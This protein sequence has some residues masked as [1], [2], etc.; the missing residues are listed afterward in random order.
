MDI[1]TF[2]LPFATKDSAAYVICIFAHHARKLEASIGFVQCVIGTFLEVLQVGA[3]EHV[4]QGQKIAM[5]QTL[6]LKV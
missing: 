3:D 5:F 1:I 6:N 4:S 2:L